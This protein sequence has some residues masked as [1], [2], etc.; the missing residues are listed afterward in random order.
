VPALAADPLRAAELVE[1]SVELAPDWVDFEPQKFVGQ[2][3]SGVGVLEGERIIGV[4][5]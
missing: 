5:R 2:D 4:P 3:E 1:Q